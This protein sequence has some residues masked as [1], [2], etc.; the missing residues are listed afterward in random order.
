ML[1]RPETNILL[2]AQHRVLFYV[3]IVYQSIHCMK[4]LYLLFATVFVFASCSEWKYSKGTKWTQPEFKSQR[5]EITPVKKESTASTENTEAVAEKEMDTLP[6]VEKAPQIIPNPT[7]IAEIKKTK[8]VED[9]VAVTTTDPEIVRQAL[10]AE[11]K[12]RTS[13]TLA[14]ISLALTIFPFFFAGALVCLII[15]IIKGMSS[16]KARYNTPE[17]LKM[18][19]TGVIISFIVLALY[20]LALLVLLF[21]IL[22]LF[23]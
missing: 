23:A 7:R 20:I 16:L 2:C 13:R 8:E 11:S 15:A 14:I 19:R 5:A 6:A 9:S 12:G 22:L 18:A 1:H 21:L 4:N 10:K 3:I 17:G